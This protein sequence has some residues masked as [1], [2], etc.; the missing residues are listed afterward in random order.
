MDV[1]EA[2]LRSLGLDTLNFTLRHL[3][4]SR[5]PEAPKFVIRLSFFVALAR[6]ALHFLPSAVSIAIIYLNVRGL[7]IGAQ[8]AGTAKYG[9]SFAPALVQVGAKLQEL[10]IGGSLAIVLFH[11]IRHE[12]LFGNGVSFGYVLSGFSFARIPYFWSPAFF[13]GWTFSRQSLVSRRGLLLC[14]ALAC[15]IIT[16]FAGPASALLM[17]PTMQNWQ[18]R[19]GDL[20]LNATNDQLWPASLTINNIGGS[21]CLNGASLSGTSNRCINN[22]Y[23]PLYGNWQSRGP[24]YFDGTVTI[25]PDDFSGGRVI[26]GHNPGPA[27]QGNS[28]TWAST[29][30]AAVSHLLTSIW[31]NATWKGTLSGIGSTALVE[32]PSPWVRV[33]CATLSLLGADSLVPFPVLPEIAS[34]DFATVTSLSMTTEMQDFLVQDPLATESQYSTFWMPHDSSMGYSSAGMIT[35]LPRLAAQ[36]PNRYGFPCT[37]DAR[38][39]NSLTTKSDGDRGPVV[40]ADLWFDYL[41]GNSAISQ[42]FFN[43]DWLHALAPNVS[44]WNVD[45]SDSGKFGTAISGLF[46]AYYPLYTDILNDPGDPYWSWIQVVELIL[47]S[48]IVDGMSRVGLEEHMGQQSVDNSRIVTVTT[49]I[50]GYAYMASATADYL[51]IA[52]LLGHATIAFVYTGY[53]LWTRRTSGCWDTIEELVALAHSSRPTSALANTSTGIHRSSTM[54][55]RV[56][57][58]VSPE[59]PGEEVQLIFGD[60]AQQWQKAEINRKYGRQN[61]YE[62]GQEIETRKLRRKPVPQQRD[63]ERALL[64]SQTPSS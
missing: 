63:S 27:Q 29:P 2:A 23:L 30:H 7:Y 28:D 6:C 9:A 3:F 60:S 54:S 24:D 46:G 14:L 18:I 12:L 15:G 44:I 17:M 55:Q 50:Q 58:R 43:L 22:G 59:S 36:S 64:Y 39:V 61:V 38:W 42:A 21:D 45:G 19:H 5:R 25:M 16:N 47:A 62:F 53:V 31:W 4:S 20:D 13:N 11:V 40:N 1:L 10:L 34:W 32:V 8:L 57:I 33:K 26:H 37:V 52:V 51:A 35:F 41:D 49:T 48:Y 56:R